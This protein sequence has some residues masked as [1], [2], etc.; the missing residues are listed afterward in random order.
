M[1]V[2]LF[3]E[4]GKMV[5]CNLLRKQWLLPRDDHI[6]CDFPVFFI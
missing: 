4:V 5:Q 3:L 2:G 1:F 6:I